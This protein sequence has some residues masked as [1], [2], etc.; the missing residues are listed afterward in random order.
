MRQ[1]HRDTRQE[2][3]NIYNNNTDQN[4]HKWTLQTFS[5]HKIHTKSVSSALNPEQKRKINR[6]KYI[7]TTINTQAGLHDSHQKYFKHSNF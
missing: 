1:N 4:P 6:I 2:T 3:V 5:F 7:A